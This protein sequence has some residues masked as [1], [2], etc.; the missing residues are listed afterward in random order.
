MLKAKCVEKSLLNAIRAATFLLMGLNLNS[1]VLG[2]EIGNTQE[3]RYTSLLQGRVSPIV[4][5]FDQNEKT[6]A[7]DLF[8]EFSSSVDISAVELF[9]E[10]IFQY[11]FEFSTIESI[12]MDES[13]WLLRLADFEDIDVWNNFLNRQNA[14]WMEYDQLAVNLQRS[15]IVRYIRVS[16][17][18]DALDFDVTTND[19]LFSIVQIDREVNQRNLQRNVTKNS[20]REID[21]DE[22]TNVSQ[23]IDS[24]TLRTTA[25]RETRLDNISESLQTSI[26]SGS[27]ATV[28]CTV[29][30]G[31][32]SVLS[33]STCPGGTSPTACPCLPN[34]ND[35]DYP[36]H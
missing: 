9:V 18:Y 29:P 20:S 10:L 11:E 35:P 22:I 21:T 25:D 28:C 23:R 7:T 26:N 33:G 12:S 16:N 31:G 3:H 8:L 36:S 32:C 24:R 34:P 13:Q 15:E 1:I 2:Q 30:S 6:Y 19:L 17:S 5:N 27:V 4:I 14:D